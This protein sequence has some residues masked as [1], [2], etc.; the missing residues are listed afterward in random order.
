MF[1][2]MELLIKKIKMCTIYPIFIYLNL[3]MQI[4]IVGNIFEKNI[5]AS[6]I[7]VYTRAVCTL[8]HYFLV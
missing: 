7:D 2:K 6:L 4:D 1:P 3:Y 5:H 8:H